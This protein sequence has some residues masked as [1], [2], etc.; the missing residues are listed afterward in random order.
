MTFFGLGIPDCS[1]S[2]PD[3]ELHE[4]TNAMIKPNTSGKTDLLVYIIRCLNY[5]M[6]NLLYYVNV[7]TMGLKKY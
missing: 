3:D 4:K 5:L 6:I 1:P 2:E 7:Q